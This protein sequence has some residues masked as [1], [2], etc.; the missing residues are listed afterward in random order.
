MK[1]G[2]YEAAATS[3]SDLTALEGKHP[4]LQGEL[5]AIADALNGERMNAATYAECF[6]ASP[7][8]VRVALRTLTSMAIA[9]LEVLTG[10]V[11]IL[12]CEWCSYGH[13]LY[14]S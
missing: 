11:F 7:T 12:L 10:T 4:A 6:R 3:L 1:Q 14:A 13:S 5:S 9:A 8:R 2:R